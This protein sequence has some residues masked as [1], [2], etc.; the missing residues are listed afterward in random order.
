MSDSWPAALY[1]LGSGNW[2]AWAIEPMV[3][4]RIMWPSIAHTMDSWTQLADTPSPQSAT[5]GL[6][7]V[8]VT[9]T[10]FPAEGRKLSWSEHSMLA[11]CSRLLTVDQMWVE[12]TTSRLR[13][14]YSTTTPLHP[15]CLRHNEE[16][17]VTMSN[18]DKIFYNCLTNENKTALKSVIFLYEICK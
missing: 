13:V 9:T 12:P 8:A 10:S 15:P 7:P 3:T 1:N 6:H 5:L 18:D 17:K 16:I 11:T 2:L 4:Q 14:W